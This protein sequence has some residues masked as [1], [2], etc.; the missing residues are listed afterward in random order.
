[1]IDEQYLFGGGRRTSPTSRLGLFDDSGRGTA[2]VP[3]TESSGYISRYDDVAGRSTAPGLYSDAAFDEPLFG[4][5]NRGSLIDDDD[6]RGGDESYLFQGQHIP[7]SQS[8]APLLLRESKSLGPP[9]GYGM[10][11]SNANGD[12]SHMNAGLQRSASTGVIGGH[13]SSSSSV[14]RSL[15]LDS[16][17][18]DLGA[19][20][21]APKTL[22]DLIQEDFPSS[23]SPMYNP[24]Q[25]D[26]SYPDEYSSHSRPRTASPPSHYNRVDNRRY[27]LEQQER[28]N[29]MENERYRME[30]QERAA[31]GQHDALGE[32][33]H[34]MDRMRVN[35][36]DGYAVSWHCII[37]A[38]LVLVSQCVSL[39]YPI[40]AARTAGYAVR[41]PVPAS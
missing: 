31:Y 14:L 23:P 30:Q 7:R 26:D 39:S 25:Q 33:T 1:M 12:Q 13:Q 29:R 24:E 20:R 3:S 27:E 22:M 21:P 9:P 2:P 4:T 16:D 35:A 17:G 18:S 11:M 32:I 41:L 28:M 6:R 10:N 15:G 19:V 38:S 37:I 40:S 8:A 5:R 34:S 36:R